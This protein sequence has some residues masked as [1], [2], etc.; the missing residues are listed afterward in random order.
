MGGHAVTV[1]QMSEPKRGQRFALI[2]DTK[3]CDAV[4]ALGDQG[5]MLV[6]EST[7]GAFEARLA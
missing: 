3:W 7:F 1:E 6:C 5:D 2:M 4:F